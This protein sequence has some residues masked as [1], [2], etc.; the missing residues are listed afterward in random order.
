M[1]QFPNGWCIIVLPTLRPLP[2][3]FLVQPRHQRRGRGHPNQARVDKGL[4]VHGV[5]DFVGAWHRF[6]DIYIS[7]HVYL[8]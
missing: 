1:K 8:Y 6:T 5:L 3:D 2:T 4:V 7:L